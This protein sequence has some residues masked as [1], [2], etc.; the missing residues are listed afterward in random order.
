MTELV[1]YGPNLRITARVDYL[2][3]NI[4]LDFAFYYFAVAVC[5]VSKSFKYTKV[6]QRTR[7]H[8]A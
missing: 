5:P 1:V 4:R 8:S 6:F 2:A 3:V 7:Y